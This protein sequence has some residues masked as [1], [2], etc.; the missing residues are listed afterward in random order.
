M[1]SPIL[2]TF[3][4]P[5]P[6]S[7]PIPGYIPGFNF[8][9]LHRG[10]DLGRRFLISVDAPEKTGDGMA[11]V[12]TSSAEAPGHEVVSDA[13]SGEGHRSVVI[14][15]DSSSSPAS[16]RNAAASRHAAVRAAAGCSV[17]RCTSRAAAGRPGCPG[18]A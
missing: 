6:I 17:V 12:F 2:I 18:P 13:R 8:P 15:R 1:H 10:R 5:I 3:F 14:T 11:L 9:L 4:F 7:I 16:T